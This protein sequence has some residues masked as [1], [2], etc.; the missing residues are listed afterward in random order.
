[1][2]LVARSEIS[3]GANID[4][5]PRVF[6]GT[7]NHERDG[8]LKARGR[9][10]NK[11]VAIRVGAWIGASAIVLPGVTIAERCIVGAGAVVMSPGSTVV[12][13]SA[14][15]LASAEVRACDQAIVLALAKA[16]R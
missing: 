13:N 7:G 8:G 15:E 4:I 5:A 3:I 11:D 14:R 2:M 16:P 9:G 6:I 10:I 1:M 12:G